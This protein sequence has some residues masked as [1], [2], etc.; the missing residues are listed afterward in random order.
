M[1]VTLTIP[2]VAELRLEELEAYA[3]YSAGLHFRH[4]LVTV[5]RLRRRGH[6]RA[7]ARQRADATAA[8]KRLEPTL[9]TSH[10]EFEIQR[11]TTVLYR[12]IKRLTDAGKIRWDDHKGDWVQRR[13]F[14]R[15]DSI[16]PP[17]YTPDE[18]LGRFHKVRRNNKGWTSRCPAHDD[19]HPSLSISE[20][21]TGWLLKCWAGCDFRDI[22]DAAGLSPQRMF[23]E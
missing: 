23:N 15:T 2:E 14:T 7:V 13:V 10:E 5:V 11:E 17:K 22:V 16:R 3:N 21:N 9:G 20:G 12:K 8:A 18:L 4:D 6:S 19:K 1:S